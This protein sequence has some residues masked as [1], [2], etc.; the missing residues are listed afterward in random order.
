[1]ISSEICF[2]EFIGP[3]AG[4]AGVVEKEIQKEYSVGDMSPEK[5]IPLLEVDVPEAQLDLPEGISVRINHIQLEGNDSLAPKEIYALLLPYLGRELTGKDVKELCLSL[6]NLYVKHGFILARV[7]PPVQEIHDQSLTL[8]VVEGSLGSIEIRGNHFYKTK[9]IRRYFAHLEG[10]PINYNDMMRALLL[11]AIFKKG[12]EFGHVDLCLIV[13]DKLPVHAYADYNTW[14][15][16]VTTY[17][18][19]G[20]KIS[21]G[22]LATDGDMLSLVGVVGTPPKDLYY[23]N[24]A[25]SAPINA[26]GLFFDISYLYSHFEVQ[27][28]TSLDLEG[29]SQI[30]GGRIR[31]ALNRS[32]RFSTDVFVSFDYKQLKNE[33]LDQTGSFDR[34]RDLALG[35]KIDYIDGVNGRNLFNLSFNIGIPYILGGSSPIDSQS[36][37]EGAGGRYYILNLEYTRIQ[38]LPWDSFLYFSGS[39]QGT[40]NKLP[41]PEQIYIGGIGTVR[42]YPLSVALG[43]TGYYG[44][45]EFHTPI[46]GTANIQSRW[47]KKPWKDVFQLVGFVDH[48]GVYTNSSVPSEASPTYLTSAG[49]GVRFYGPWNFNVSFDAG[50]PLTDQDKLFNNIIYL[51][52]SIGI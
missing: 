34:L 10:K 3:P 48:G 5:E 19:V 30:A 25:Y 21:G 51:K 7:F 6:Q 41:L 24:T 17:G 27:Q 32:R 2:A 26:N 16:N 46:P 33:V 43:D 44:T 39:A 23:V 47:L 37:R 11:G 14:G 35:G 36:S 9:Y 1:M 13:K 40:F 28:M 20:S 29:L 12:T 45:L 52:V 42:G 38:T 50:F 49:A 22:N 31:Q 8:Q 15:S 18:R 4:A